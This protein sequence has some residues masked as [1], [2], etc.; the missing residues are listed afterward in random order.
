MERINLCDDCLKEM[1]EKNYLNKIIIECEAF[2]TNY[3][4]FHQYMKNK[5]IKSNTLI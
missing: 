4:C 1:I 5:K 2:K 3:S